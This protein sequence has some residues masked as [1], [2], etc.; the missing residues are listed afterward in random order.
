MELK[1]IIDRYLALIIGY[2]SS[3]HSVYVLLTADISQLILLK[4]IFRHIRLCVSKGS[5]ELP[6]SLDFM[7]HKIYKWFSSSPL[8]RLKYKGAYSVISKNNKD[9]LRKEKKCKRQ[10]Q[11]EVAGMGESKTN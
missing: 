1:I 5:L 10:N 3:Y 2:F 9:E 6:N 4:C 11:N 8:R 7:R